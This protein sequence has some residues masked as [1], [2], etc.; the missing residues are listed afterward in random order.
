MRRGFAFAATLATV[1]LV[2]TGAVGQPAKARIAWFT[3]APHPFVE[4]FRRGL[5]EHAAKA[6]PLLIRSPRRHARGGWVGS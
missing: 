3:V 5:R 1:L 6:K 4:S 2:A